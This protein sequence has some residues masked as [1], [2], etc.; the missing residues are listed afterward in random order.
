MTTQKFKQ[1]HPELA[2]LEGNDLWNAMENALYTQKQGQAIINTIKPFWKHY[3]LRWLFYMP[4]KNMI[5]GRAGYASSKRCNQCKKGCD[6]PR[7]IFLN[8]AENTITSPCP[9]CRKELVPESNTNLDHLLYSFW[10][11]NVKRFRLMLDWLHILRKPGKD[12]YGS[13]GD[14]SYY[15]KSRRFDNEWNFVKNIYRKR[16][17]WEYLFIKRL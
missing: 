9:H 3:Q 16:K 4:G 13:F 12:R 5:W 14:E 10:K 1:Q 15:V 7:L 17:W 8:A 2:H 6:G 11:R